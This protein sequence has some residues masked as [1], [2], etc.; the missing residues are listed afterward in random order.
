MINYWWCRHCCRPVLCSYDN[1]IRGLRIDTCKETSGQNPTFAWRSTCT[2]SAGEKT[3]LVR[4]L[5]RV[6]SLR[7]FTMSCA[8]HV[9]SCRMSGMHV[10]NTQQELG[11]VACETVGTWS[12]SNSKEKLEKRR[13]RN[14][15]HPWCFQGA[16]GNTLHYPPQ[17]TAASCSCLMHETNAF[18]PCYYT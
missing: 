4:P 8:V 18:N 5:D 17:C 13:G 9:C 11:S 10:W 6:L 12:N 2:P 3:V 15:L 1:K 14:S 7:W 16:L